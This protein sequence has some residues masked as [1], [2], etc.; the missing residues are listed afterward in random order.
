MLS[1]AVAAVSAW[2]QLWCDAL[3]RIKVRWWWCGERTLQELS[4]IDD[5]RCDFEGDDVALFTIVLVS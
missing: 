2:L 4:S 5:S 1:S 3:G